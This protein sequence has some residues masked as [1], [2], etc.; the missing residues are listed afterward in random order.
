MTLAVRVRKRL[1]SQFGLDVE[2]AVEP[3][4]TILFGASGSGKSTL[5]RCIA[6][7]TRPDSGLVRVGDDVVFD[8]ER[9]V[10]V[11][12]SR[13]QFGFLFQTLALFPHLTI[14]DNIAYG[15][16]SLPPDQRGARIGAI[17]ESFRIAH[18]LSRRP[19]EV[20]GG[21]RQRAGLAR[22]LVAAPRVLLLDEPLS[23]LDYETQ[24]RIIED[25]RGW[26]SARRI[27]ILYVTHSHREVF[28]LGEQ[29]VVLRDGRISAGGAPDDVMNAPETDVMAVLTGFENVLNAA[30]VSRDDASGVMRTSL[31]G[32]RTVLE[33]PLTAARQ[34]DAIRVAIR[35]GDIIA[36]VEE[37]HGLSA[38]N[39]LQGRISAL[40]REGP[41]VALNVD[42]GT[43]VLVYVTPA[44]CDVLRLQAGTEVWLVIKTH[45]CRVVSASEQG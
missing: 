22:S 41:R 31:A 11:R 17:A 3:G 5:L 24:S 37:P 40:T 29:V 45:S 6:G 7:L 19:P 8:G 4:V 26:N 27:P 1:S 25:L 20:S 30:V 21:E 10:D 13:R 12:P 15:L 23:A 39:V 16:D 18:L 36:A 9:G 44:A 42:I 33:V 43:T 32:S 28:A 34:G 14:A 38:R 35:A 2:L